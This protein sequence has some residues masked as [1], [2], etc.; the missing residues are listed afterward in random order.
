MKKGNLEETLDININL[1]EL[2]GLT[3][4]KRMKYF[5]SEEFLLARIRDRYE[6]MMFNENIITSCFEL[7]YVT[8]FQLNFSKEYLLG[9][10]NPQERRANYKYEYMVNTRLPQ[11][12]VKFGPLK[13]D[14]FIGSGNHKYSHEGDSRKTV[15]IHDILN[16]VLVSYI[17]PDLYN[18][19]ETIEL[20]MR[21]IQLTCV[22][23]LTQKALEYK[24]VLS[25]TKKDRTIKKQ[26]M[27]YYY[28]IFKENFDLQSLR[29]NTLRDNI[30]EKNIKYTN[31][32]PQPSFDAIRQDF[33]KQNCE[34][35]IKDMQ[36]V[37]DQYGSVTKILETLEHF[38]THKPPVKIT[39]NF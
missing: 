28:S 10:L 7:L 37:S 17:N 19:R 4:K 2:E 26:I 16:E 18:N 8:F 27:D 20:D 15:S 3:P 21:H 31:K 34:V 23:E 13:T 6:G 14:E 30:K 12:A 38:K 25:L 5:E 29:F 24:E 1:N 33:L 36:V 39:V 11:C 35:S 9:F 32:F 22:Y